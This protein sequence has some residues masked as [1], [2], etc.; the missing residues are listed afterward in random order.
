MTK[1]TKN[2]KRLVAVIFPTEVLPHLDRAVRKSDSDR[3]KF[4]R[5]AVR[6]K[7]ARVGVVVPEEDAR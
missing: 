1:S 7:M 5:T 4:I 3:S 2:T 6:E